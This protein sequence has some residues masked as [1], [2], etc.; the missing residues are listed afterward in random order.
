MTSSAQE[1]RQ[2]EK[3]VFSYLRRFRRLRELN[4]RSAVFDA[5]PA[6]DARERCDTRGIYLDVGVANRYRIETFLSS[7]G[8]SLLP[9]TSSTSLSTWD[10]RG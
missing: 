1:I 9:T 10:V 2:A 4:V 8:C 6:A 5:L 3:R 7:V